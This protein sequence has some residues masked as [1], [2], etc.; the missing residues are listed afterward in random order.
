MNELLLPKKIKMYFFGSVNF[1][2][3][4]RVRLCDEAEKGKE[5]KNARKFLPT[6]VLLQ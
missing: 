6:V 1:K 5:A 3:R 2:P 4:L